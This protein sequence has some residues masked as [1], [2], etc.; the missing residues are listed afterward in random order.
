MEEVV[1]CDSLLVAGLLFYVN[2]H[3]RGPR[4]QASLIV[5][6][7]ISIEF[8]SIVLTSRKSSAL[9][10]RGEVGDRCVSVA[11]IC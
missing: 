3:Q 5:T 1:Q 8:S 4:Q 11:A 7:K 10:R 2:W 6:N 9:W